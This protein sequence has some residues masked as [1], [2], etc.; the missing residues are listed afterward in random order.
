MGAVV[1]ITRLE[2]TASELRRSA[3]REKNSTAARRMLALA[4]VLE[5]TDRRKAAESCGMDRQTLRDW[6]HRYNAEGLA[7]L[8]SRKPPG[9]S[10]KLTA[11]QETELAALVEAGP[12]PAQHGVVRWRRIDLRDEI[13]RRFGVT[14][15]ERSVGKVLAKLGFRRLSV[16]PRH[17]QSDE[18]AQEA[19][20]KTLPRPLQRRSQATPK[21][22]RSKSGSKT[23][24]GSANRVR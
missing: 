20:K 8:R 1:A 11:Q 23:K 15:H 21:A 5:G 16:R 17:P 6:V 14:L 12:D 9:P 22:S 7:G 19:F 3:Q 4:L 24:R 18:A 10:S 2:L 13:A